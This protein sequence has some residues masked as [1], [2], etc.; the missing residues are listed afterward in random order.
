[1]KI[2]VANP[3]SPEHKKREAYHDYHNRLP[4]AEDEQTGFNFDNG[5]SCQ[6]HQVQECLP[7]ITKIWRIKRLLHNKKFLIL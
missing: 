3:N 4:F 5:V 6:R 1:M 2:K 7:K